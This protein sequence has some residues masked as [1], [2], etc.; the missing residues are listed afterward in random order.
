[1]EELLDEANQLCTIL[2]ASS[3][4]ATEAQRRGDPDPRA[5]RPNQQ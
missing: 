4:T 5:K 1:V 3:I 2:A